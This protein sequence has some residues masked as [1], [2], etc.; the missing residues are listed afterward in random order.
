MA[1]KIKLTKGYYATV[2]DDDYERV[3]RF[4]WSVSLGSRVGKGY[5]VRT[6][7]R[8]VVLELAD[9]T[10]WNCSNK[11][12]VRMH[13]FIMGL[14]DGKTDPRVVD[15]KNGDGLDNRKENLEI[16]SQ[17]ENMMRVPNWKRKG[18]KLSR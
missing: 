16:V 14:E 6:I 1:K 4:K 2:D 3:R 15:H 18:V 7:T 12:K 10:V 8:R 17:E 5:A 9:G 11:L 13:R